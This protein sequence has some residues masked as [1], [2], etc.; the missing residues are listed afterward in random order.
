M[1][2][3]LEDEDTGVHWYCKTCN[4]NF[5]KLMVL[6]SSIK[7]RHNILEARM[8]KMEEE[9]GKMMSDMES[10]SK[11]VSSVKAE[12]QEMNESK[13][14]DGMMKA[15]E[16][17]VSKVKAEVTSLN[18]EVTALEGQITLTDTKLE[19]AIEA[20]LVDNLSKNAETIKKKLEPSWE[21][22]IAQAVDSKLEQ[23]SGDVN[24][25]QQTLADV[26]VQADEEK[27]KES[28]SHNVIIYRVSESGTRE[29]RSKTDKAFCMNLLKTALR[30]DVQDADIKSVFRLGKRDV[31][32]R[33]MMV[34]FRDNTTKNHMMESLYKLKDADECFKNISVTHDLTQSERLE[35]KKL[36]DE[37][38]KKQQ[39]EQGEYI[40]RVRGLPGQ[41]KLV[42]IRKSN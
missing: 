13:L 8:D 6:V 32:D 22:V 5:A 14:S 10:V 17:I 33:P 34:Q 39:E 19:T 31:G 1:Y 3:L 16:V 42:K 24:K 30:L 27:D 25:V 23:V 38:K 15:I 9:K 4:K 37:A 21:S 41:L 36:V 40:W 12:V 7:Q 11:S 28:R 35:C 18:E 29:E 2:E 26:K 20:K